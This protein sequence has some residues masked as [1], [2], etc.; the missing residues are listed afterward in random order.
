MMVTLL[1]YAH[2]V[3]ERSSWRIERLFLE[4][5]AFRVITAN[6]TRGH[7][8][9]ARISRRHERELADLFLQ[10]LPSCRAVGLGK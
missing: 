7:V 6:Q 5:V 1:L 3:G 9:I 2:C 10:V 4:D 8:T